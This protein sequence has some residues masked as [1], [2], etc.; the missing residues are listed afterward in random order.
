MG[1][2]CCSPSTRPRW[3]AATPPG[4]GEARDRYIARAFAR[5]QQSH[6]V[7]HHRLVCRSLLQTVPTHVHHNHPAHADKDRVGCS[8][9][10][11]SLTRHDVGDRFAVN[12]QRDAFTGFDG[13]DDPTGPVRRSRTP[14]LHLRQQRTHLRGGFPFPPLAALD[15]APGSR[16]PKRRRCSRSDKRRSA[17]TGE[18][19][20]PVGTRAPAPSRVGCRRT[21]GS[22]YASGR[23]RSVRNRAGETPIAGRASRELSE[24]LA[25]G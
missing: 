17:P 23:A 5:G 12:D 10:R 4:A 8:G 13:I 22:R 3:R 2:C 18:H 24:A 7:H 9:E 6:P 25:V 1:A 21:P 14:R 16:R 11:Q 19:L 15:R 20:I